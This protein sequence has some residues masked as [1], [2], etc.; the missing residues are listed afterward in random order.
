MGIFKNFRN[1]Y[2]KNFS[3]NKRS[4]SSAF[5]NLGVLTPS[6]SCYHNRGLRNKNTLQ[7]VQT[8]RFIDIGIKTCKQFEI[9]SEGVAK[10]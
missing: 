5:F 4:N 10:Y 9:F 2:I 6:G 7:Q 1:K 8:C 3:I